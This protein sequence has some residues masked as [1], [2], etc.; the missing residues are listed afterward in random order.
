[1]FQERI[2]KLAAGATLATTLMAVAVVWVE[3]SLALVLLA[4]S[5]GAAAATVMDARQ[6]FRD[7]RNVRKRED[8]TAE[9]LPLPAT[10]PRPHLP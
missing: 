5:L 8:G 3:G 7:F 1:M 9:E 2:L 6:L 10:H 4:T